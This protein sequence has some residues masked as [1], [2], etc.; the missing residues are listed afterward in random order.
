VRSA[1]IHEE[2]QGRRYL[3]MSEFHEW[4]EVRHPADEEG[5]VISITEPGA[6][7]ILQGRIYS[8]AAS[9]STCGVR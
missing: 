6:A 8:T 5:K 3:D 7:P 4:W 9:Y 1:E 2:W